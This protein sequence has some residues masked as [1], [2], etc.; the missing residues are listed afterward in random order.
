MKNKL[1]VLLVISAMVLCF[2]GCQ[3]KK[4]RDRS[5]DRDNDTEE[6]VDEKKLAEAKTVHDVS[7]LIELNEHGLYFSECKKDKDLYFY[8]S[9]LDF[10]EYIKVNYRGNDYLLVWYY[11]YNY[12]K[13]GTK[14]NSVEKKVFD[15]IMHIGVDLEKEEKGN[16]GCFPH[17]TGCRL[18]LKLDEDIKDLVVE[19]HNYHEYD[20]GYVTVCNKKGILDKDLNFVVPLIYDNIFDYPISD[21]ENGP[22]YYRVCIDGAGQGLLDENFNQ[23]LSTNYSNIYY[24]NSDKIIAM[25]NSENCS[26]NSELKIVWIDGDENVIRSIPGFL[27]PDDDS[28]FRCMD[29]HILISDPS[30]GSQWG[31]GVMDEDLNIII[32]PKYYTIFWNGEGYYRV[33]NFD[34]QEALFSSTGEQLTDFE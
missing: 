4:D 33:E 26:D 19:G 5:R 15:G 1:I 16:D 20:G 9:L 18:I 29:G 8:F 32:E 2:A 31:D 12:G 17:S 13:I 7:D 3:G 14:V 11:Y 30:Y 21:D 6:N 22:V 23:V 25:I 27:H 10:D 24:F 28:R 34:Q